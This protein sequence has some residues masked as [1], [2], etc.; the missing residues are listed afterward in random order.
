MNN[1]SR[2]G[3]SN[4]LIIPTGRPA[5]SDDRVRSCPKCQSRDY[6][7]KMTAGGVIY[8]CDKCHEKFGGGI[9]RA[10]ADPTVPMPYQPQPQ[11]DFIRSKHPELSTNGVREIVRRPDPTPDFRKG[12]P[13]KNE[14]Q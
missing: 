5:T 3:N 8:T 2:D 11:R 12:A 9:V 13:I 7:G 14:D 1:F 10:P 4:P 6:D